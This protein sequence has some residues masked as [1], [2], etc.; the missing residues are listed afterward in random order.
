MY[1]SGPVRSMLRMAVS[2]GCARLGLGLN[3]KVKHVNSSNNVSSYPGGNLSVRRKWDRRER[4]A[5]FAS[6]AASDFKYYVL[7]MDYVPD[8][9]EKRGP[10]R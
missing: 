7:T 10:Y 2:R 4:R 3:S 1:T 9:L 5:T 6:A 8:I